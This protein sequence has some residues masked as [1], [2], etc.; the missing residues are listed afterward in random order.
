MSIG[1]MQGRIA[2]TAGVR[3]GDLDAGATGLLVPVFVAVLAPVLARVLATLVLAL[4]LGATCA[5][6]QE[7]ACAASDPRQACSY[8]CCGRR[9]CPPSC[10][11]DCVKVCVDACGS[12]TRS[13]AYDSRKR[14]LQ[15]RC[16]NK[17][18]R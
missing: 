9:S 11:V 10:E 15:L 12:Q 13:L 4:L 6:A 5:M 2:P 8:Q 14:D 7:N 18:A 17:G 3:T 1:S 16:G